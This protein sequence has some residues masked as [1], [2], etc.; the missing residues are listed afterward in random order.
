L[1]EHELRNEDGVWIASATP[2]EIAAIPRIP[3]C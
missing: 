1:L 2:R 3:T